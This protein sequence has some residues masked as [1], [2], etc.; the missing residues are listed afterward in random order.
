MRSAFAVGVAVLL[1]L[2]GCKKSSKEYFEATRQHDSLVA[3]N[4]EDAYLLPEMDAVAA[5]LA[6]V[7][8]NA[9]EVVRARALL[10]KVNAEMARMRAIQAQLEQEQRAAAKF[11]EAIGLQ[12]VDSTTELPRTVE[13]VQAPAVDAGVEVF[14]YDGMT[15][16]EFVRVFG[17]CVSTQTTFDRGQGQRVPAFPAV[18]SPQ[19]LRRLRVPAKSMMLFIDGKLA[20]SATLMTPPPVAPVDAGPPPEQPRYLLVPGAPLPPGYNGVPGTGVVPGG[21]VPQPAPNDNTLPSTLQPRT[22]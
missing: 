13:A 8:D 22:N 20:G 21:Q 18:D 15:Q 2:S 10:E 1:A 17:A 16:S 3:Q 9:V 19:C 5:L 7:P 12:R 11:E 6:K 14:P 4:G